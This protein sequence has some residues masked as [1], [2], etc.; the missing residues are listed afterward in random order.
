MAVVI[1]VC[2]MAVID[3]KGSHI[4]EYILWIVYF[5][6]LTLLYIFIIFKLNIWMRKMEGDF[7]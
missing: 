1:Y 4:S 3:T 6:L 5:S 2:A 7:K